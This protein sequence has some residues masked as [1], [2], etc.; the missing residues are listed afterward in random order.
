MNRIAPHDIEA[1]QGLLHIMMSNPDLIKIIS[2]SISQSDFYREGHQLIFEAMCNIENVDLFYI[3]DYL[4]QKGKYDLAG[5]DEYIG[6]L[7]G[8]TY[9]RGSYKGAIELL[10]DRSKKRQMIIQCMAIQDHCFSNYELEEIEPNIKDLSEISHRTEYNNQY[11][12]KDLAHRMLESILDGKGMDGYTTGIEQID[13]H[14]RL[15][16]GTVNVI[17][18]ESGV[19][20]SALCFQI[21]MHVAEK[22]D[23]LVLYFSLESSDKAI[24]LRLIAHKS[25]IPLTTLKRKNVDGQE[26]RIYDACNNLASGNL[27][28]IDDTKF[29]QCK[30][31][32]SFC[33]KMALDNKISMVVIDFLQ[34]MEEPGSQSRHLEISKISRDISGLA[35]DLNV[36]VIEVSQLTK[37]F[38][39]RPELKHLK[40]SGDIRNNADNILFIHTPDSFPVE[41][42][43]EVF[44]AKGKDTDRFSEFLNFNG[45]FQ[46]FTHGDE[47][48]FNI[49]KAGKKTIFNKG[50][51]G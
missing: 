21:S 25:K 12:P 26:S 23:G 39:G 9:P 29:C 17:A 37:G 24:G 2:G 48:S 4:S 35:K 27:R 18:A 11:D 1:E 44:L 30:H 5:G 31:I 8:M 3:K 49:A 42:P 15:E 6:S 36:P 14:F 32:E 40:E 19:G 33:H 20:K 43:V 45:N 34:D 41:Y 22:Y 10:K 50:F 51:G 7:V 13:M 28:I 47:D 16:N 46:E 38:D